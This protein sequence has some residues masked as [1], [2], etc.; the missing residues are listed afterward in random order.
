MPF[1]VNNKTK[2]VAKD[3]VNCRPT[4]PLVAIP[5]N[6]G[7]TAEAK[8]KTRPHDRRPAHRAHEKKAE[9]IA[10][11]AQKSSTDNKRTSPEPEPRL[12]SL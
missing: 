6:E 8:G 9:V 10:S 3:F 2:I 1:A 5:K 12:N 4:A 7:F 11:I